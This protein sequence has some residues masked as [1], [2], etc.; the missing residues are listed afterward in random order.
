MAAATP[1]DLA[2]AAIEVQNKYAG[3]SHKVVSENFI[4]RDC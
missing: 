3:S 2:L 4:A 1:S